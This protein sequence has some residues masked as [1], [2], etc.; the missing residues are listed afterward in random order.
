MTTAISGT[1]G[2]SQVQ[3]GVVSDSKLA[4]TANSAPIKTALNAG[5][6]PPIYATRAWVNF[7]GTGTIAIRAS[8]N[9]AGITDNGVGDYSINFITA[10]PDTNYV[11]S[12][13]CNSEGGTG[14]PQHITPNSG[15]PKSTSICRIG[16]GCGTQNSLG[17][18]DSTS[19]EVVITR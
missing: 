10:M 8:G 15:F 3:D 4:L 17:L 11:I 12:G 16:A 7:N 14:N 19:V 2:V 5:G 6:N 13:S 1:T 18:Y 9:V